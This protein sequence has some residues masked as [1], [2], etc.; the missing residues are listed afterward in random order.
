[1]TA[2]SP[3]VSVCI[4][5]FNCDRYLHEAI[6]SALSQT[7]Q[8]FELVVVDNASTDGTAAVVAG[9]DDPRMVVHRNEV[10][11]GAAGNWNRA[12]E[13]SRGEYVKLLCA[14]D[15]LEPECL[16][17]QVSA[18]DAA[19][20]ASL[21]CCA[22]TVIGEDGSA[23]MTRRWGGASRTVPAAVALRSVVRSGTNLMGDPSAVI[24]RRDAFDRAGAF[25]ADAGYAI[26]MDLWVRLLGFGDVAVEARALSRY[27]VSGASWSVSVD[28]Q[29]AHDT[30]RVLEEA[31][32]LPLRA[33][34]MFDLTMGK[35]RA[36]LNQRLRWLFYRVFMRFGW[37]SR[38]V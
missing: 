13:L 37:G 30:I 6:E 27:R 21:C 34:S 2:M 38:T 15:V 26:D 32:G 24:F 10:N 4:P 23:Q 31:A 3:K 14:D 17:V 33:A 36:R 12:V 9:F 8:D 1:M 20:G 18:L 22:R 29:Q 5:V 28:S 25:H 11:I 35:A 7:Y 19:P 16:A